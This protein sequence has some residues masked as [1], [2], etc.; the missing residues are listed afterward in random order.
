MNETDVFRAIADPTRRLLLER[1]ATR[2]ANATEL[3]AGLSISQPA[4][5]QHLAVLRT[6]G[7]LRERREGRQ[8]RYSLAPE[9]LRPLQAWLLRYSAFWPQRIDALERLLSEMDQ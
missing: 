8:V 4:V 5:S 1:L 2:D 3:R 9:G 6:A 7:L